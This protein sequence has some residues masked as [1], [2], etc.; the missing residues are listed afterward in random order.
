MADA[1]EMPDSTLKEWL[2]AQI[3]TRQYRAHEN[4][5]TYLA[6]LLDAVYARGEEIGFEEGQRADP[7][8]P[9]E[10]EHVRDGETLKTVRNVREPIH[11]VD[12]AK[13]FFDVDEDRF[14]PEKVECGQHEVPM[15]LKNVTTMEVEGTERLV[16]EEEGVKV[17]C[18]R[19]SV[20]WRRATHRR[21]AVA[22]A[23]GLM[24]DYD[25]PQINLPNAP[26]EEIVRVIGIPDLHLGNLIWSKRGEMEW[27]LDIGTEQW[28]S[29]FTYLM[30]GAKEDGV[31]DL[32]FDVGNDAAHMN[33][34]RG[35][36]A[37]GTP[38]SQV[39][40]AHHTSEA[41]ARMY[42]WGVEEARSLGF[43]V[44]GVVVH[45]N[46]D[47]DPADWMGRCLSMRFREDEGTTI[48]RSADPW[49]FLRFGRVLL[50]FTHGKNYEG[51][52]LAPKD[53]YALAA[54]HPEWHR[55]EYTEVRTG[56]T[57]NRH[58]E[59]VGG[60]VEHKG[61]LVRTSPTLCPAD[62]YHKRN[63][64]VGA[65]RAAEAHDYHREHGL[66]RHR[67]YIPDLLPEQAT[68]TAP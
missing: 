10:E 19:I 38:Y 32:V 58:L 16:R 8:I 30:E 39:A 13:E 41:M 64:Y 23:E 20:T 37:N 44:H 4:D 47:F 55:A 24:E 46:H 59:G 12:E 63:S 33:G 48:H 40:P 57:H 2:N 31:T 54:E 51:R 28:R 52:L 1:I 34:V 35:E 43:R 25:P 66:I 65:L 67:P 9:P 5:P 68:T 56:H 22:F 27:N 7:E 21:M 14:Y 45:G 60:Y 49:Q 6:N 18:F 11:S 36:S 61:V 17:P 29:A 50:G 53:L 26:A 15:K 3:G 42:E 62:A